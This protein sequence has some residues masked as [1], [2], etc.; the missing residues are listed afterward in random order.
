MTKKSNARL[1]I[2]AYLH[3]YL[4]THFLPCKSMKFFIND[5]FSKCDQIRSFPQISPHLLKKFLMKNVIFY[6]VLYLIHSFTS[7]WRLISFSFQL[8]G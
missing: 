3:A 8:G 6:V 1:W 2:H 5:F 4:L 7:A